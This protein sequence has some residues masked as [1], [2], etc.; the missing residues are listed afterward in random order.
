LDDI[1]SDRWTSL[2]SNTIY[3]LAVSAC[4]VSGCSGL[5]I[6]QAATS[7][8]TPT[9]LSCDLVLKTSVRVETITYFRNLTL[10]SSGLLFRE[11]STGFD[12]G[13]IQVKEWRLDGLNPGTPYNFYI[14][15]RNQEEDE[16]A[17]FGP[18]TCVTIPLTILSSLRVKGP[19]SILKL[20][21]ISVSDG[22]LINKG[23]IKVK[24]SDVLTAAAYLVETTDANASPVRIKTP[25]GIKS[26]RKAP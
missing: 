1:S 11:S 15:A 25:M 3:G 18:T 10:T 26:W 17:E 2:N 13:Y 16:T 24:L 20:A 19:V 12:S 14:K 5:S 22:L 23:T 21:L 4:N 6:A 8:E 7:I 9:N